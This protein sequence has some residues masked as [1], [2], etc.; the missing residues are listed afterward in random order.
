MK[1]S[2][3][4]LMIF[5]ANASF[6]WGQKTDY[7]SGK[8]SVDD[9]HGEIWNVENIMYETG[10]GADRK[11]H[12]V[13]ILRRPSNMSAEL[14]DTSTYIRK[15][16]SV[17]VIPDGLP[18]SVLMGEATYFFCGDV[19]IQCRPN[20]ELLTYWWVDWDVRKVKEV[21]YW[22]PAESRH[23]TVRPNQYY[24]WAEGSIKSLGNQQKQPVVVEVEA[25][26]KAYKFRYLYEHNLN[27]STF[28]KGKPDFLA[29]PAGN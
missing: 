22:F 15:S 16:E 8:T 25:E 28:V 11:E 18:G 27:D 17:V 21:A 24:S 26:G 4:I 29:F 12:S 14:P 20:S 6:L 23:T 7:Y 2:A 13:Y 19:I 10:T 5:L 1:K 3:V 9:G